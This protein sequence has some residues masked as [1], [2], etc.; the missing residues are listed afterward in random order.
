MSWN[1]L[2]S[3]KFTHCGGLVL[4]IYAWGKYKR[5]IVQNGDIVM[6]GYVAQSSLAFKETMK[7]TTQ[8]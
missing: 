1:T 3:T 7:E 6:L 5:D 4:T 2:S 8:I